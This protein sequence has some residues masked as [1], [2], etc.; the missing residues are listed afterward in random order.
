METTCPACGGKMETS[1]EE[2][3][4]EHLSNIKGVEHQ[5]CTKCGEMALTA[6]QSDVLFGYT[7]AMRQMTKKN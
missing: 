7:L 5:V 4:M 3:S 2:F 6:E 1:T